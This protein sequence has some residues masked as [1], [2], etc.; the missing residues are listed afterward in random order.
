M[1]E[2]ETSRPVNL[3]V[4]ANKTGPTYDA[5][6]RDDDAGQVWRRI[7]PAWLEKDD[8]GKWRPRRGRVRDGYYDE[9]RAHVRAAELVATFEAETVQERQRRTQGPSFRELA[10]AYLDWLEHVKGA[11]PS[12]LRQHRSDLAE[13][14]VPYKR[15]DKVLA[16][17]IMRAFGDKPAA[18]VTAEDVDKLLESIAQTATARSSSPPSTSA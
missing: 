16:G 1:A 11:A 10:H 8:S 17:H 13:P 4:R 7:G 14:G 5:V 6:F 3:V 9:R 12:T 18:K 2:Q 15:G